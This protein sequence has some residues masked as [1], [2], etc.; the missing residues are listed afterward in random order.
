[1][2]SLSWYLV[3]AAFLFSCGLYTALARRNAIAVL[4][5]IELLLNAVNINL[6]AFWRWGMFPERLEGQI[7]ALF[8]IAV[9][10]AEAAVG[11][12]LIISIYR[13]RKTVN[14]DQL[15]VLKG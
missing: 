2:V 15:D 13:N 4:M 3:L 10:A 12:A 9:A 5:G 11:L 1:M 7:F 8:V 6:V 14:L